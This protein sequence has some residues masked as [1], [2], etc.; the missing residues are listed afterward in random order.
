M[1]NLCLSGER[2]N[3]KLFSHCLHFSKYKSDKNLQ[4]NYGSLLHKTKFLIRFVKKIKFILEKNVFKIS[5]SSSR[6][7]DETYL[8][9]KEI[10]DTQENQIGK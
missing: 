2:N 4:C 3:N 9:T 10:K 5:L 8:F 1:K 7:T 6:R